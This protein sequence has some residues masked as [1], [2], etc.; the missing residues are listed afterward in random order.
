MR[1]FALVGSCILAMI[2]SMSFNLA[3]GSGRAPAQGDA[4]KTFI[5]TWQ[6]VSTE[7]KGQ[8]AEDEGPHPTGLI[9]YDGTGHMAVQIMPDRPR[10]KY[11]GKDPTPDEAKAALAGYISY[12]GTYTV[13]PK[14]RTVTHHRMGSINP[15]GAGSDVV[16]QFEFL[17]EDRLVLTPVEDAT[18]HLTWQRLK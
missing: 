10:S 5:G 6:L 11:A 3:A 2:L 16:R 12:F 9:Y 17:S 15:G 14:T 1:K 18:V 7:A 4:S 13:D 8:F